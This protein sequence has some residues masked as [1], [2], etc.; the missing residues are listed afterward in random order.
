[1]KKTL[2]LALV[3]G[4]TLGTASVASAREGCGPGGH[5]GPYG[6]C[7]PNGGPGGPVVG[8]GPGGL[9]IGNFY[10]G[11]GY[12]DGHRYWQHRRWAHRSWSYY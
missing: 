2:A 11:R 3:A 7:R 6:H 5:R 12:W 8:V 9:V 10:H 1:M 4:L